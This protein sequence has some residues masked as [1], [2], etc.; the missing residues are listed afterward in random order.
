MPI[1]FLTLLCCHQTSKQEEQPLLLLDWDIRQKVQTLMLL[2]L[3]AC[4]HENLICLYCT[5][6]K[7]TNST[8]WTAPLSSLASQKSMSMC[9]NRTYLLCRLTFLRFC[10]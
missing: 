7:L 3:Y 10:F 8:L 5:V 6:D 4:T 9:V 1:S 2:L